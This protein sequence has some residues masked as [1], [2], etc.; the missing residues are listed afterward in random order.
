MA[1]PMDNNH[2]EEKRTRIAIAGAGIAGLTLAGILANELNPS[3]VTIDVFERGP[4]HSDQGY[5][6]DLNA[7]GQAALVRAG[8][9]DRYW[10][11][12]R[13]QSDVWGVFTGLQSSPVPAEHMFRPRLLNYLFPSVFGVG[14]ETNRGAMR[15]VLLEQLSKHEN[16]RVHFD[17]GVYGMKVVSEEDSE[18]SEEEEKSSKIR[19]K[20]IV[21]LKKDGVDR[22]GTFD[23]VVDAM[24]LH[25]KLRNER[26]DDEQGKHYS[27]QLMIHGGFSNPDKSF[28]P[29]LKARV[30]ENGSTLVAVPGQ[31]MVSGL[32]EGRRRG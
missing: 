1:S 9:Y 21:L 25:S 22:L 14:P 31:I 32:N 4:R 17:C 27:G 3:M 13:P 29:E 7:D 5:G 6:L 28:P 12:S 8:V 16:A 10:E 30:L 11:M 20:E 19:K 26:V 24:G 15:E 2:E 18:V 23:L